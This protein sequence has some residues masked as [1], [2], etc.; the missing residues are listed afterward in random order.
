[1]KKWM[2]SAIAYLI[3]IIGGY[4]VI[5]GIIEDSGEDE[6]PE[7]HHES[8]DHAHNGHQDRSNEESD[9]KVLL[10]ADD[11]VMMI[12]LTDQSGQPVTDLEI[13]HEKLLHLIIVDEHLNEYVHLHPEEIDEGMF[14]VLHQ[15]QPGSYKAFIDIKPANLSYSVKPIEFSIGEVEHAHEHGELEV[16][17]EFT[18]TVNG[19]EVTLNMSTHK[20]AEEVQL[21]FDLDLEVVEPYLG[22]M[23]HVVI[24][25]EQAQTYLHVHPINEDEPI[26]ETVF[27]EPGVYKLWA[28][29]KQAGTVNVYPFVISVD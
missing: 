3:I 1:M 19:H 27:P 16:D 4:V 5:T 21:A 18:K 23:G 14:Q 24:L 8:E 29:F 15:L 28:E 22:A 17:T 2:F 12:S 13:N 7:G 9:V 11:E 10:E 6:L 20:A 26:F 25:D